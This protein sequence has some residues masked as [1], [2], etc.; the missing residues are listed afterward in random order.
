MPLDRACRPHRAALE[1]LVAHDER[2]PATSGALDHLSTC[3]ACVH[4]LTELALTVAALHRAGRELRAVPVPS[5]PRSRVRALAAPRR[6]GWSLRLQLGGL[7]TGAAIAA[8]VVVP[9]AGTTVRST[10]DTLEPIRPAVT[11]VWRV[12]ESRIAAEPDNPS[13]SA[14]TTLPPRYPEGLLRPWKEVASTDATPR[15]FRPR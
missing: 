10:G 13:F 7:L 12:A 14:V 4:D 11:A 9:R 2:G 1:A 5:P 15:A 6:A 8:L 3:P